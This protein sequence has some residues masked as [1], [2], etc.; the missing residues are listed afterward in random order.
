MKLPT[1][2]LVG[3][4][5][6]N[7]ALLGLFAARPALAPPAFR[8]FFTSD[9]QR[10]AQLAA[11][12]QT[13][14]AHAAALAK[15]T[16]PKPPLWSALATDDLRTLITRLRAAGF[17]PAVIRSVVDRQISQLFAPRLRALENADPN[18]P[19]WKLPPSYSM[20]DRR[21]EDINQLYRERS[22]LTR[23]LL[24]DHALADADVTAAQ[25]RQ[26][27]DLSPAKIDQLQR[28][29]ED[30]GEMLS[31]L[32]AATK[33]IVLPE[34]QEK[35]AL[36]ARE[37]SAD[38]AAVLTPEELADYELRTSP[39][40]RYLRTRLAGFDPSEAEF[41]ALYQAQQAVNARYAGGAIEAQAMDQPKRE[42]AQNAYN[43][44]L[45]SSLGAARYAEF[46]R[47]TDQ[48]FQ[49]LSR[50]AQ[51]NNIPASTALLAYE[52]RDT[53]S[54]ESNRI[55]DNPALDPAQQRAALQTLAQTT[56]GQI[57]AL[58]GSTVGA[59]YAQV[60]SQWLSALER[61][62]AFAFR[63]APL[64]VISE[65]SSI[66]FGSSITYRAPGTSRP[67]R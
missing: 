5:A 49:Q 61:G 22:R 34:D 33:G 64:S 57:N 46:V 12:K 67:T 29:E 6:A 32:R 8:D 20:G 43:A 39:T 25:R 3:S 38:L 60:A 63:G 41:R 16:A 4:V 13:A 47:T 17:P 55:L 40:T 35:F 27:G 23:E 21:L 36:L 31:S 59:S 15:A 19:F 48:Q 11:E 24:K 9:Q 44:Q 54:R 58:L 42:A 65:G 52:L 10:A 26:F 30:Y 51:Q 14:A 45:L 18:L 62:G 7:A 66:S 56:R 50:L 2:L 1:L 37:K 28:I 53:A